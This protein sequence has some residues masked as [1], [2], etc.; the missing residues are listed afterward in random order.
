MTDILLT[1][2][3]RAGDTEDTLFAALRELDAHTVAQTVYPPDL[4]FYTLLSEK[5]LPGATT[6]EYRT[7]NRQTLRQA[8][9]ANAPFP[10]AK[11][12]LTDRSS[13]LWQMMREIADTTKLMLSIPD[14]SGDPTYLGVSACGIPLLL[15][16]AG[17]RTTGMSSSFRDIYLASELVTDGDGPDP[18]ESMQTDKH[19]A[20]SLTLIIRQ[21]K[22]T[23]MVVGLYSPDGTEVGAKDLDTLV[24]ALLPGGHVRAFDFTQGVQ[25]I[26]LE[27][28]GEADRL[29]KIYGYPD[30][31]VPGL[32]IRNSESGVTSFGVQPVMRIDGTDSVIGVPAEYKH[33]HRGRITMQSVADFVRSSLMP[34]WE[35]FAARLGGMAD[36][37]VTSRTLFNEEDRQRARAAVEAVVSEAFRTLHISLPR[38]GLARIKKLKR[39]MMGSFDFDTPQTLF[40]IY[41]RFMLL[42]NLF[43]ADDTACQDGKTT[44]EALKTEIPKL[45]TADCFSCGKEPK[46]S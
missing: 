3:H 16:R 45:I 1:N 9:L 36:T 35:S 7:L 34:A 26:Y 4:T 43:D 19:L 25:K 30:R 24:R 20:G 18:D 32:V 6:Y 8:N 31:L 5:K 2:Y 29:Q 44:R 21:L 11:F 22:G 41:L 33:K 46:V 10:V 38:L 40:D 15:A 23:G 17:I 39:K 12:T 27:Y 13:E 14:K 42:D 28:D 37:C